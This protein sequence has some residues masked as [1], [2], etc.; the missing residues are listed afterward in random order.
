[1]TQYKYGVIHYDPDA[2]ISI[3]IPDGADVSD[4]ESAYAGMKKMMMLS[5]WK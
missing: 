1:M 2:W 4:I 5:T 3:R